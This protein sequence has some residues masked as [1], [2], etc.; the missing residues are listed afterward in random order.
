[1]LKIADPVLESLASRTLKECLPVSDNI[2]KAPVAPLEAFGRLACGIASWLEL[3]TLLGTEEQKRKHYVSMFHEA[4]DAATDPKSADYMIFTMH[5]GN[6]QPLV[7]AAFLCHAVLRAPN[8]IVNLMDSRVKQNLVAALHEAR[9]IEPHNSNW[10]MF[11]AMIETGLFLLTSQCD[12]QRINRC[13]MTM[14]EWYLGDGTY[15]DGPE[16]AFDYYNSFVIQPMLVDIISTFP[17]LFPNMVETAKRRAQR[18]AAILE[19][20]ISP[21]GTYPLV[22][23]SICYRFGAFQLLSQVALQHF[24]PESLPPAQVRCALTAVIRRTLRCN[25]CFDSNGWLVPGIVGRQP[26]LMERY[27]NTGSL[28]LCTAVYLPLGLPATDPFWS[29]PNET[30]TSKK[31]YQ[32]E[33]INADHALKA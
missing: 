5:G 7:D 10:L 23:R 25:N 9:K 22:G 21:E 6:R 11:S 16:F 26:G 8:S 1:M 30:W 20:M 19:H 3:Q 12:R 33:N 28:Y 29:T 13:V 18:Y 17:D 4:L 2:K 15:G 14:W 31:I 27:I 24:L 32:G